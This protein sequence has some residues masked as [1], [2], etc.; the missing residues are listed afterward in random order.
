MNEPEQKFVERTRKTAKDITNPIV[1]EVLARMVPVT[2]L[3]DN[4]YIE[5][6]TRQIVEEKLKSYNFTSHEVRELRKEALKKAISKA[7]Q[8]KILADKF[9][10][11]EA[12]DRKKR[13]E[14]ICQELAYKLLDYSLV[15]ADDAYLDDGIDQD[16][17]LLAFN[18]M[19]SLMDALFDSLHYSVD[20][21][22]KRWDEKL[23][24][25]AKYEITLKEID[26]GL[27]ALK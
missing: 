16:E 7:S 2:Y 1:L 10:D 17:F 24:G 8:K 19:K 13:C 27:K 23:K 6:R 22:Y 3:Y 21:S 12:G 14:P 20:E 26:E 11:N 9:E 5:A 15:E 18:R 25:K 4:P